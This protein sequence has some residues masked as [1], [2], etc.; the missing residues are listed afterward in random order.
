MERKREG[1]GGGKGNGRGEGKKGKGQN[2]GSINKLRKSNN[3]AHIQ[4]NNT[5]NRPLSNCCRTG[6]TLRISATAKGT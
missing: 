5:Q 1:M 3:K 6:P 4:S 2:L